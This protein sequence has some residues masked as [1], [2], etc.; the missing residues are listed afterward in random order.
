[1]F[2]VVEGSSLLRNIGKLFQLYVKKHPPKSLLGATDIGGFE[3][4]LQKEQYSYLQQE[5]PAVP[6]NFNI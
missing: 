3:V 2:L 4:T 6:Q 5:G 1:V